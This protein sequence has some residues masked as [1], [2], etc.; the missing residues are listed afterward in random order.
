MSSLKFR[1]TNLTCEACIKLSVSALKKIHCV[2]DAKVE[3]I[4]GNGEIEATREVGFD[5]VAQALKTVGK[6]VVAL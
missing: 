2:T 4:S 3:I 6:E 1:I 5:E